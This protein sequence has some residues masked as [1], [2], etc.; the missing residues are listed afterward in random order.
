MTQ[1][2]WKDPIQEILRLIKHDKPVRKALVRL[3]NAE[4]AA[5]EAYAVWRQRR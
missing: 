2:A 4:A 5:K 1:R 3:L